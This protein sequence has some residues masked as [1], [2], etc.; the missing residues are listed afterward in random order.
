MQNEKSNAEYDIVMISYAEPN[1]DKNFEALKKRFPKAQRIH[2]VKG[3]H[4]AHVAAANICSTEM[5]W[6]VDGDAEVDP[7]FNFDYVAEDTRAVPY[8]AVVIL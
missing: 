6:I 3:I 4:N 5:F 2:G 1:A 7:D 8:G